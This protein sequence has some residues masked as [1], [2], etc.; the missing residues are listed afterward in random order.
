MGSADE[1]ASPPPRWAA[2]ALAAI[3]LG[4]LVARL[5]PLVREGGPLG[6]AVDYDEGVYFSASALLFK[7]VLPYRD[8]VFVHPPGMLYFLGLTSA[9][10]EALDP[11]RA[12]AAAR[13][14]AVGLGA[15][16]VYLTGRLVLR[17]A[18]CCR[19]SSPR[20]STPPTRKSSASSAVLISSQC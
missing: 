10:A 5:W 15:V 6:Y 19:R 8:F 12:F 11:A 18:A 20:R 16:N 1:N 3:A 17:S 2:Y 13:F 14:V 9:F 4:G 7:G